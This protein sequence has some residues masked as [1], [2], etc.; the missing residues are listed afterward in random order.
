VRVAGAAGVTPIYR[1]TSGKAFYVSGGVKREVV[2]DAALAA[3]G[4]PTSS[5]TLLETG[6][7]RLPY[8]PPV[9][10]DGVVLRNRSSRVLTVVGGGQ[11]ATVGEPVV[12][13]A[14]AGRP[15]RDLDD[16]SLRLLPAPAAVPGAF[17]KEAGGP[18]VFLL[19]EQG[20]RL[21]V[22]AGMVPASVPEM[23]AGVLALVPDAARVEAD[24]F[25]KGSANGTVFALRAGQLRGIA[26][27]G[28]LIAL[29]GGD[30]APRILAVDQRVVDLLPRGPLQRA[31]GTMVVAPRNPTVYLVDGYDTLIP[32]GSFAVTGELGA[33]RLASVADAD[34]AAYTVRPGVVTTGLE[35]AGTRYLGL[36][37]KL[38]RVGTDAAAHYPARAWTQVDVTTCAALPAGGELSRFLR[39]GNGTIFYVE[40]GVKRPIA[41]WGTYLALGGGSAPLIQA[42]DYSLSLIPDGALLAST[43]Q[44][45]QATTQ[46]GT[47]ATT[48]SAPD[49][50][51]TEGEGE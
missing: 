17:V 32:V 20:K 2:D 6:L 24:T 8:G 21:V 14:F 27:W 47:Q 40:N 23:P 13:T 30:P 5:V 18:R 26:G 10:R 9:I 48:Q 44:L 39:A 41:S 42:S 7:A 33:S 4:L 25:V 38:Y 34:L 45:T 1:T 31:P 12:A 29:N 11:L 49:T 28:D 37:G 16:A 50:T 43:S 36:G 22:D 46:A 51:T 35:C 15:V 3:G 19:T